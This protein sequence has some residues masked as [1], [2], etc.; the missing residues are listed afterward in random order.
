[1]APRDTEGKVRSWHLQEDAC[2]R[3]SRAWAARPWHPQAEGAH[4]WHRQAPGVRPRHR[5]APGARP[6]HRQAQGARLIWWV[7]FVLVPAVE[8]LEIQPQD[9]SVSCK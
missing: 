5:E 8:Q 9:P 6:R 7:A 4:Q 1:M 3:H 2:P